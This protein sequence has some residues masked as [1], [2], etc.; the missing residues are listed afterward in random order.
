MTQGTLSAVANNSGLPSGVIGTI[1]NG[2][3]YS[4]GSVNGK[5]GYVIITFYTS[6]IHANVQPTEPII[7]EPISS[8]FMQL[9]MME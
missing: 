5:N 9:L 4:A 6:D 1:G 2:A 7:T 8:R 3:L